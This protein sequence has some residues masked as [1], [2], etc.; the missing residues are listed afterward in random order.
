MDAE[1]RR[2]V[3]ETAMRSG[4]VPRAEEIASELA[5][6]QS[7]IVDVLRRLSDAHI[8]V[9]RRDR[10]E[11]LMAMPFS[12]V[13]TPFVVEWR[14]ASALTRIACGTRSGF[15]RCFT[16]PGPQRPNLDVANPERVAPGSSTTR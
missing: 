9:L 16:A 6:G 11:I 4:R 14:E 1:V 2:V 5:V 12:A 15:R 7:E 3:Y 8:L 10:N 13:P